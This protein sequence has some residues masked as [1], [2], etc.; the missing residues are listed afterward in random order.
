[1]S[2]PAPNPHATADEVAAAW[3]DPSGGLFYDA[4]LTGLKP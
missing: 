1:M 4:E 2:A 3:H